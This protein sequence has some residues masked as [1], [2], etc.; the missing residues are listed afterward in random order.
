MKNITK[1]PVG[2]WNI[3]ETEFIIRLLQNTTIPGADIEQANAI[4]TKFKILHDILLK[5]EVRG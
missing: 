1:T 3:K 2:S 4:L 5:S